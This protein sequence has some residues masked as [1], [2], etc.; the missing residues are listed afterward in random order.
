MSNWITN[1]CIEI[2]HKDSPLLESIRCENLSS[3]WKIKAIPSLNFSTDQIYSRK[4][5]FQYSFIGLKSIKS[6]IIMNDTVFDTNIK[7][8][9]L[10]I[11]IYTY[12]FMHKLVRIYV[13]LIISLCLFSVYLCICVGLYLYFKTNNL[14]IF[15]GTIKFNNLKCLWVNVPKEGKSKRDLNKKILFILFWLCIKP[16][17]L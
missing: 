12:S 8:Y 4:L 17:Q 2:L 10:F 14:S 15:K 13:F 3:P 5:K 6:T 16:T 7:H 1:N 9:L 11:Y